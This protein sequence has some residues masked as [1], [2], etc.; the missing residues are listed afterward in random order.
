MAY[1]PEDWRNRTLFVGKPMIE[2]L[3]T[4]ANIPKIDSR[5]SGI[6]DTTI[7]NIIDRGNARKLSNVNMV[8]SSP[9][10]LIEQAKLDSPVPWIEYSSLGERED[11]YDSKIGKNML[12]IPYE[13][14]QKAQ[15]NQIPG[16]IDGSGAAADTSGDGDL[17]NIISSKLTA[18]TE[19]EVDTR[20]WNAEAKS[21]LGIDPNAPQMPDW[22]IPLAMIGLEMM[23]P[24]KPTGSLLG[25]IAEAGKKALPM[26][27]AIQ[28]QRKAERMQIGKL[29][30]ELKTSSAKTQNE[31]FWKWADYMLKNKDSV[32][33]QKKHT[34]T[35]KKGFTDS[36]TSMI[37]ALPEDA[38]MDVMAYVPT[39]HQDLME[40]FGDSF[41]LSETDISKIPLWFSGMISRGIKDG[42]ID[43]P[44]LY[45]KMKNVKTI[46]QYTMQDNKPMKQL[47][48][49][50]MK[51]NKVLHKW[52]D[53][54]PTSASQGTMSVFDF[55]KNEFVQMSGDLDQMSD[56]YGQYITQKDLSRLKE[57]QIG[58]VNVNRLSNNLFKNLSKPDSPLFIG[59][60]TNLID[61]WKG[62]SDTMRA[63]FFNPE[64]QT[65][66]FLVDQIQS[67]KGLTYDGKKINSASEFSSLTNLDSTLDRIESGTS[68]IIKGSKD[69][70]LFTRV[71]EIVGGRA[72]IYS[73]VIT[74]GF[75]IANTREPGKLTDKDIAYAL[76]TIGF[77]EG[78]AFVSPF[79]FA[80]GLVR[81]VS[82]INT[83]FEDEYSMRAGLLEADK[84]RWSLANIFDGLK[85][86]DMRFYSDSEFAPEGSSKNNLYE[87]FG[88][89]GSFSKENQVGDSV[90][91]AFTQGFI[92]PDNVNKFLSQFPKA[93]EGNNIVPFKNLPDPVKQAIKNIEDIPTKEAIIK[94][95]M[96]Y[97]KH[98]EGRK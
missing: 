62:M 2:G 87:A 16:V 35:K 60:A 29:A 31:S 32:L 74:L 36:L 30:Y 76:R 47:V 27:A 20:D 73:D 90:S 92:I 89:T 63:A 93:Y 6:F 80:S 95:Y 17:A 52:G 81:A 49:I 42:S 25:D 57:K 43:D 8:G 7:Q 24:S 12:E 82:N 70:Q 77:D 72:E 96:D 94:W 65:N 56:Q 21:I 91:G 45:K 64:G 78:K 9:T 97:Q 33:N 44:D 5:S 85:V 4:G 71:H 28:Q 86:Q 66:S 84:D 3:N 1:T 51:S 34:Y 11:V 67:A 10:E 37:K 26:F 13:E 23:S 69:H 14:P 50:D 79:A 53:P 59:K 40:E 18:I 83:Q 55:D 61:V 54:V 39:F 22:G 98:L 75:A 88:L 41:D 68:S 58:V 48:T 46:T 15:E 38:R 19:G